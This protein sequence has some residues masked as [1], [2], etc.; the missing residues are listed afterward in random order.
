MTRAT[1]FKRMEVDPVI[2]VTSSEILQLHVIG[3]LYNFLRLFRVC[4]ISHDN[5]LTFRRQSGI[6]QERVAH[7]SVI[8][9]LF[10]L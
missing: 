7:H 1:W 4:K 5:F 3:Q 8:P 6:E 10:S 2:K 9:E